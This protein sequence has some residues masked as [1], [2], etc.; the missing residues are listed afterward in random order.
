MTELTNGPVIGLI[1]PGPGPLCLVRNEIQQF[2]FPPLESLLDGAD[3]KGCT[4]E[5][6]VI[7]CLIEP[8]AQAT[9]SRR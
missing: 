6:E 1:F 4:V 2:G 9:R 3:C 8:H 7:N 5:R